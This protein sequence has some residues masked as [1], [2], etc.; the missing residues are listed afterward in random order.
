MSKGKEPVNPIRDKIPC[1]NCPERFTAC[2][3][4]CPK[5]A[6]GE[7]GYKAWKSEVERVNGN[8]RKYEQQL[9]IGLKRK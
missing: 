9:G 1:G 6:R 5:D 7:F 3:D 8:R 2:S 4:R